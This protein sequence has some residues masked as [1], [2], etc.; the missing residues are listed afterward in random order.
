MS[1]ERNLL[2]VAAAIG[3]LLLGSS[4]LSSPTQASTCPAFGFAT[5]CNLIITVNA[6]GSVTTTVTGQPP[7]DGSEDQLVGVVNNSNSSISSF[8]LSGSFIFGF[9]GDGIDS[10]GAPGNAVDTT[11]Y[12]GPNAYFTIVDVNSGSVNFITPI[13]P[14]GTDYFSLEEP[15]SAD[16]VITPIHAPEP[17]SLALLGSG[18]V[19]LALMRRRR[20][21]V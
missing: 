20:R 3:G 18:L 16:I 1:R 12:G 9:D 14:G 5:D 7:Y 15:A 13:A 2:G 19:G 4:M 17:A 8:N 10:Y 6:D 21:N 11:G